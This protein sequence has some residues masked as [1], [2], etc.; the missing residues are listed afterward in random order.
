MT[1]E[2]F[3]AKCDTELGE[4][5]AAETDA[6]SPCPDCGSLARRVNVPIR[7]A[8]EKEQ[9]NP[10]VVRASPATIS[11]RASE[12]MPVEGKGHMTEADDTM[13]GKGVVT[14]PSTVRKLVRMDPM[15]EDGSYTV[16][17]YD[18]DDNLIEIVEQP[19]LDDA[20]LTMS[21]RL[22]EKAEE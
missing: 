11:V 22:W 17:A 10:V 2:V 7:P 14:V 12:A 13:S 4:V 1:G 9:A 19:T 6:N 20:L 8:T 5:S 21:D 16:M 18:E 15:D 3:C